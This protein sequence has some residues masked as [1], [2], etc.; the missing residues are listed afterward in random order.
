MTHLGSWISALVDG[1]LSVAA[2]ER[3]LAHVAGCPQCAADLAAARAARTALSSSA[4]DVQPT[5]DLTARLLSLAPAADAPVRFGADPFAPP[6]RR[7][8]PELASYGLT[9]GVAARAWAGRT[10]AP[11]RG[12]VA[13]RRSPVR[14]AAGSV[15]GLGAVAAM[16]FV[17]GERPDVVPVGSPGAD[18]EALA[19][20]VPTGPGTA[21]STRWA[22]DPVSAVAVDD[23]TLGWLRSHGW[24]VPQSLPSGW[25]VAAVR[26]SGDDATVLEVDVATP[27]G[28]FVVTEQQGRLDTEQLAAVPVQ[29]VRGRDV[30]VLAFEPWHVAWQADATVVQVIGSAQDDTDVDALVGAFPGGTFD[31]GVPARMT[32][33]WDTVTGAW[34]RP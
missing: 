11:L 14:L 27:T 26:W 3:A 23:D 20:A 4:D 15:A 5:A 33:G 30:Y 25:S 19:A 34:Q 9:G 12:Q 18:L 31:D 29:Q 24:S 1:Q 17:L 13:P 28:S 21:V 10:G 32:R 2:T 16:L 7:S 22:P 8:R 6:P